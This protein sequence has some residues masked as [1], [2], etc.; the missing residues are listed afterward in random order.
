MK[1]LALA[2]AVGLV[3][4]S[5]SFGADVPCLA[6]ST[7]ATLETQVSCTIGD[8]V[9]S[10]FALSGSLTASDVSV[11]TI[12]DSPPAAI[13]FMFQLDLETGEDVSLSYLVS[14]ISGLPLIKSA[15]LGMEGS[16]SGGGD[17]SIAEQVF[18]G[19]NYY[20]CT[21]PVLLNTNLGVGPTVSMDAVTFAPVNQLY[22]SKDLNVSNV[23]SGTLSVFS[24][25][26]DQ[27]PEPASM[28]LIGIGLAGLA[29]WQRRRT[30]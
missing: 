7:F 21:T 11:E 20:D 4:A 27:T 17:I 29:L 24:E 19:C 18:P 15:H 30:S 9:F 14:T 3:F 10:D 8:K 25:T 2:I 12:I 23:G 5:L 28:G 16:A 26:V 13:G 1:L 6:G 22:V